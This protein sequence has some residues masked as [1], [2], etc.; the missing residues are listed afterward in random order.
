GAHGPGRRSVPPRRDG[1]AVRPRGDAAP[2]RGPD[3]E[4]HRT[5]G[6]A[7][8]PHRPEGRGRE[9]RPRLSAAGDRGAA[10]LQPG[11]RRRGLLG[12]GDDRLDQSRHPGDALLV[13]P[14]GGSQADPDHR[15]DARRHLPD[16]GRPR[17]PGAQ[18]LA[19]QRERARRPHARRRLRAGGGA[20]GVRLRPQRRRDARAPGPRVPVHGREPVLG[21]AAWANPEGP[22]GPLPAPTGRAGSAP[23]D[24][25]PP[26]FRGSPARVA[27]GPLDLPFHP[28]QRLR[29]GLGRRGR[30]VLRL[31]EEH[32]AE[33]VGLVPPLLYFGWIIVKGTLDCWDAAV[34]LLLYAGYLAVLNRIPPREH[35]DV[36]DLARVPLAVIR[37]PAGPRRLAILGLFAVGALV[38]YLTAHPFLNSM[39]GLATLLGV[40]QFV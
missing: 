37:L 6:G 12:R 32:A 21:P 38:L 5:R 34:L 28:G 23:R 7:R 14:R 18:E 17:E 15:D 10:P 4:R 40:S 13:L 11:A 36:E 20:H 22:L 29:R 33:V 26:G 16:R 39:I 35:E 8:P 24:R 2:A 30:A 27:P 31:D 1:N 19:L 25:R 3:R 9:H